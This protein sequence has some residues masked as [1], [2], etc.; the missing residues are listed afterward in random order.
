VSI[1]VA[2]ANL[3]QKLTAEQRARLNATDFA[4]AQ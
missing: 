3:E 2:L 4:A 1:Q